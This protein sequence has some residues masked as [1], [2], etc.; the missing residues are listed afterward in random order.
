M[1]IAHPVHVLYAELREFFYPVEE[2]R[3]EPK[4]PIVNDRFEVESPGKYVVALHGEHLT[5]AEVYVNDQLVVSLYTNYT[6]SGE[7]D[8]TFVVYLVTGDVVEVIGAE[9]S[10]RKVEYV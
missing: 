6:G 7:A 4:V 1:T 9:H 5:P 2:T 8:L 3:K 10:V